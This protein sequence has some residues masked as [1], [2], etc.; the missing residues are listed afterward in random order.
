MPNNF[1]FRRA[2]IAENVWTDIDKKVNRSHSYDILYLFS[3]S[4]A[5][6]WYGTNA[7]EPSRSPF[8]HTIAYAMRG[9]LEGGILADEPRFIDSAARAAK[10]LLHSQREDG[11]IAGEFDDDW[12]PIGGYTCLTGIA[13]IGLNWQRLQHIGVPGDWQDG[14]D[15]A[16][17]FLER[18]H[19]ILGDGSPRDGG[20]AGSYPIWGRYSRFEYPNWAAKFFADANM[21]EKAIRDQ[22]CMKATV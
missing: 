14:I 13:Q 6:G 12:R 1:V 5:T 17:V 19:H 9:L 2:T 20:L 16:I 3:V 7:F 21:F 22:S 10:A 15:R 8:T 11:W 4:E 18:H